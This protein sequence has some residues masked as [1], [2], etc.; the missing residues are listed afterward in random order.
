M[1]QTLHQKGTHGKSCPHAL[2]P[3]SPWDAISVT[4]LT[5]IDTVRRWAKRSRQ[6]KAL[7]A[8]EDWQLKDMGIS[9]MD[10]ITEANKPFWK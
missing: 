10:A 8:L 3:L 5:V 2:R 4:L 6:R 9:R 1:S 7:A